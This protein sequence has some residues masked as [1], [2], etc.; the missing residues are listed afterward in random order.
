[1]H[2][3]HDPKPSSDYFNN[4]PQVVIEP[5]PS[6]PSPQEIEGSPGIY[7]SA[8]VISRSDDSDVA[9]PLHGPTYLEV[10]TSN[11]LDTK[12]INHN[13]ATVIENYAKVHKTNVEK[14]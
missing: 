2:H 1:M 5:L 6:I 13:H 12:R 3:E 10:D 11:I 9:T 7:N 4:N 8:A 14:V